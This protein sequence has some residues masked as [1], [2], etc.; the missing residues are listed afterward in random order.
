MGGSTLLSRKGRPCST[1]DNAARDDAPRRQD[2]VLPPPQPARDVVDGNEA[3]PTPILPST[4]ASKNSSY[5]QQP[6]PAKGLTLSPALRQQSQPEISPPPSSTNTRGG[7]RSVPDA[8]PQTL[9]SP[10]ST[11]TTATTVPATELGNSAP[12]VKV[13]SKPPVPPPV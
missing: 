2:I 5:E 8:A 3:T 7:S 10:S 6:P 13:L 4:S 11:P 9:T 12:F 1:S